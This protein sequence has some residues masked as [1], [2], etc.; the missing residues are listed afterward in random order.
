MAADWD[1]VVPRF[2]DS[3]WY[4]AGHQRSVFSTN[5]DL[6]NVGVFC[7]H[8]PHPWLLGSFEVS[9]EVYR[10]T[11]KVHWAWVP[12]FVTGDGYVIHLRRQSARRHMQYLVDDRPHDS[13]ALAAEL[14]E[15]LKEHGPLS[16]EAQA[17]SEQMGRASQSIRGRIVMECELCDLRRVFRSENVQAPVAMLWQ[18]GR[19]ELTLEAFSKVFDTLGRVKRRR[20]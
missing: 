6:P 3:P 12:E 10:Q 19:R 5:L 20:A 9:E 11:G 17:L 1:F 4:R 15:A 18:L 16:A 8:D 7:P 14:T 13:Q 2:F